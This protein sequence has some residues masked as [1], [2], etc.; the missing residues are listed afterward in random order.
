MSG[1]EVECV[2]VRWSDDGE[3]SMVQGREGP[4]A[5]PF[6]HG[7]DRGINESEAEVVVGLDQLKAS[8]VVVRD[9]IDDVETIARDEAEKARF[10]VGAEPILDQP[11]RLGHDRSCDGEIGSGPKKNAA[12]L[13]IRFVAITSSDEDAGVDEQHGCSDAACELLVGCRAPGAANIEGFWVTGRT[14]PD[15]GFEW[16][17]VEFGDESVDENLRIDTAPLRRCIELRSK[18][19]STDRHDAIVRLSCQQ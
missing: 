8:L 9:E 4:L 7:D 3:V 13:M 18:F 1:D 15:E 16:I 19:V 17:V 10:C 11:C 2:S 6:G 5:E 12:R 14:D